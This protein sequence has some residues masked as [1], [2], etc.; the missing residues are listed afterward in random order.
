[1]LE[2]FLVE[3]G[4]AF[5]FAFLFGFF[6]L[7]LLFFYFLKFDLLREISAVLFHPLAVLFA[8]DLQQFLVGLFLV[9]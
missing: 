3:V 7:L 6:F 8:F 9:R 1:M 4:V 5:T 2:F